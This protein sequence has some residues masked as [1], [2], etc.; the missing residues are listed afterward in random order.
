M[1]TLHFLRPYYLLLLIPFII[2]LLLYVRKKRQSSA[3]DLVCEKELLPYVV[4]G[5]SSKSSLFN[6]LMLSTGILLITALAGPSWKLASQPLLKTESGL[7][8]ALDL[9][10]PMNGQDI[11]PSRLQRAIYKISDLLDRRK[12]GQTAL[13][14]FTEDA[15][16]VTPLTDDVATIKNLLNIIDTSIMPSQGHQVDKAIIK[17]KELLSQ[18]GVSN[19]SILLVTTEL[20]QQELEKS[21]QIANNQDVSISVLGVGTEDGAPLSN[22]DGGFVKDKKG[23]MILSRLSTVNLSSLAQLT[24][25]KYTTISVDDSDI[26]D[27]ARGFDNTST[28]SSN[29]SGE[30]LKDK[31][32]DQG[33]WLVLLALPFTL[34]FFRRGILVMT[35]VL[36][37][38]FLP[39]YSWNDLWKKPDQRAEE[40]FHQNEFQQ[41]KELFSNHEWQAVAN[42]KLG[43]FEE[44]AK[45]YEFDQTAEGQ[46]NYGTAKAKQG[47]F[48]IA[49][50]AYE[51]TLEIEPNH[52]DALYNK[53]VIEEFLKQQN[54]QQQNDKNKS[55]QTQSDQNQKSDKNEKSDDD[56]NNE[57]D[58]NNATD[59]TKESG[60]K[61]EQE[62]QQKKDLKDNQASDQGQKKVDDK[63][64]Q[65]LMEQFREKVKKEMEKQENE[66]KD[67]QV[68]DKEETVKI[69]PQQ[70]I[71]EKWLDR[72]QDD[73]GALL[74]RKFLYQYQ[75]SKQ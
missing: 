17:A 59:D 73:P 46:Y 49:L 38:Q 55:N 1:S 37:P 24:G 56:N 65:E 50:S 64:Y 6:F 48:E 11:K 35:L 18:A 36:A 45:M 69:D 47:D 28:I 31:W 51:K 57:S 13:I 60:Q 34:L 63:E 43:N 27:L 67:I 19:G 15:Y 62:H 42:Y 21:T 2:L 40:L 70:Q 54:E 30:Q 52:E 5:E 39:A 14:V 53:Q 20:S 23:S 66:S 58:D 44:A 10:T 75:K 41:A 32:Q 25:G 68:S 29:E 12:E 16:I 72:V 33:F 71:D 61:R 3:W 8:I 7:V 74:R 26:N 9:S 22:K 4:V